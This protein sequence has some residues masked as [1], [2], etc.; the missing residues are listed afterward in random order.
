MPS[1]MSNPQPDVPIGQEMP[2]KDL[3]TGFWHNCSEAEKKG[4]QDWRGHGRNMAQEH[5]SHIPGS[6]A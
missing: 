2:I 4:D 3:A 1:E 5:I 6:A